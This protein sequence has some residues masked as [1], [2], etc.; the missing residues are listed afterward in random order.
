MITLLNKASREKK[1]TYSKSAMHRLSNKLFPSIRYLAVQH[2]S[3]SFVFFF[4][5]SFF[6]NICYF[7]L[8]F[9]NKK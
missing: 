9:S 1:I 6:L 5:F 7:I 3:F 8:F 4:L 2:F